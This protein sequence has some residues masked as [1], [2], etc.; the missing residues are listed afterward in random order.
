MEYTYDDRCFS[1]LWKEVHGSRPLL[2]IVDEWME[3]PPAAKQKMWDSLCDQ[4]EEDM[5]EEK[6]Q[7]EEAVQSFKDLIHL[8]IEMGAK[9]RETA[10]RWM[11][12]DLKWSHLQCVEHWVWEQG[13]LFTEYGRRLVKEI[14]TLV[15]HTYA[16]EWQ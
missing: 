12:K 16:K 4:L 3:W 15:K 9:D 7:Q 5:A 1:D 13:I 6:R 8:H 14:D 11:V 10:L 2:S